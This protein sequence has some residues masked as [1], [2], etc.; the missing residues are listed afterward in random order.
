[1]VSRY[2]SP[3]NAVWAPSA[4]CNVLAWFKFERDLCLALAVV[5]MLLVGGDDLSGRDEVGI[6]EDMEVSGAFVDLAGRLD[7]EACGRH[8]DF[9]R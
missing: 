6:D 5:E 2:W 8:H 1:M 9:E 7:H 4:N 3:S